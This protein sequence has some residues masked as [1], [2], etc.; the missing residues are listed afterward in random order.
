MGTQADPKTADMAELRLR[1]VVLATTDLHATLG[2]YNYYLDSPGGDPGLASAATMVRQ[3]R[4]REPNCLL[5]DNGDTIQGS[6]MGDLAAEGGLAFP[7]PMIAAMNQ[8]GY[9][10]ATL[11]N[12]DFNYGLDYLQRCLADARFPVVLANL[13]R[14][15]GDSLLPRSALLDRNLLD[16]TGARHRLRIGVIGLA[17]PQ[18]TKWD[19]RLLSGLVETRPIVESARREAAHLRA[20][21]ADLVIALCHSGIGPGQDAPDLE[22]ALLPLAESGAVDAIVAGHT[23]RALPSRDCPG[24]IH[25]TPVVQPG[26]FGSHLG[27]ITL[28]LRQHGGWRVERATAQLHPLRDAAPDPGL[29]A[30]SAPAHTATLAHI[31]RSIGQTE[32]PIE[33]YFSLVG[34]CPALTLIAEAT[35]AHAARALDNAALPLLTAVAPFKAGGRGGPDYYTDIAAGPLSI[36]HAADLYAFPNT[37]Q[38]LRVTGADL[39]DWLE[40]SASAFHRIVPGRAGQALLDP[41]FSGY[42]F[43]V[44]FGLRYQIDLSQPALFT[45]EGDPAGPGPGRI[46]ALEQ[47]GRPV[48][49]TQEFLVVTNSYRA[50]GGGHFPAPARSLPVPS[51]PVAVRDILIRHVQT[52]SPLAPKA[53][54]VWRFA[55]MPGTEV[56]YETGPGALGHPARIAALGL[57]P[58]GPGDGGLQRFLLPL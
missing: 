50:A 7:H 16:D 53:Q 34:P 48:T 43:D 8:M 45:A 11:G 31:R 36:R 46:R 54:E 24:P 25:G 35:Q 26:F 32:T 21:G 58:L 22:N 52:A 40:R 37:L 12:H 23:H 6:P 2:P 1:L 27:Q 57:T 41:A 30:L 39:R 29:Q 55:P 13:D 51:D 28:E 56:I 38:L 3:I 9:D 47:G 42:N 5:F 10:A 20:R 44:I 18:I 4:A 19:S 17:P 49:D 14:A 33:T 15:D